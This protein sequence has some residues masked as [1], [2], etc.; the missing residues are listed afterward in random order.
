MKKN[1]Y[2]VYKIDDHTW[3]L[4]DPFHT[5]LYLAEGEKKAA[6]IDAGNG[7]PGLKEQVAALTDKPVTVILTHGHFDHT[8]GAGEF[9]SCM[10]H[11]A[12]E[13]VLFQGFDH[14]TRKKQMEHFQKLFSVPLSS[15]TMSYLIN[16]RAPENLEFFQ[17]GQKLELGGRTLEVVETPGHTRGS[18]CFLDEKNGYLFA[19]DTGCNREILVYF[20]HSASV[21]DVRD[22]ARKLLERQSAFRQIWPGHHEC[23]MDAG[24]LRDYEKAAQEI[25]MHP[26]VGEKIPLDIGYKILYNYSTI[27]ISYTELHICR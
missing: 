19:G 22:S 25:L 24:C 7:F 21:E 13:P 17:D 3:R 5:Y 8:G 2:Q 23:P 26:G 6:L 9:S 10:V 16:A 18:V 27:G 12:D 14:D 11:E 4:E 1:C 20:D 15:E